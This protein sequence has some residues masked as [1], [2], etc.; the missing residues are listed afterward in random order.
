[1]FCSSSEGFCREGLVAA[2]LLM[3]LILTAGCSTMW[4]MMI[5]TGYVESAMLEFGLI[6]ISVAKLGF[7]S[8]L[9]FVGC[10][11]TKCA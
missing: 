6:G 7:P 10:Q 3:E 2:I 4:T 5:E 1:M 8:P 9:N 11:C